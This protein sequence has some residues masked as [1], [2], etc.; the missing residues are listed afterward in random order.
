MCQ[1]TQI[2]DTPVRQYWKCLFLLLAIAIAKGELYLP[3]WLLLGSTGRF[4]PHLDNNAWKGWS[5]SNSK[6]TR[7]R[8]G[9]YLSYYRRLVGGKTVEVFTHRIQ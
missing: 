6:P 1:G 5:Q 9:N 4:S 2:L 7:Q 8:K 3:L